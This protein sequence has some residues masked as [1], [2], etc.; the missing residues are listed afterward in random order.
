MNHVIL[1]AAALCAGASPVIV[2]A[3]SGDIYNLGTLGGN[4]SWGASINDAGQVAGRSETAE[5]RY[6]GFRYSGIPGSGGVMGDI[7]GLPP[8]GTYLPFS[9][10]SSINSSG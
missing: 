10:G 9:N 4:Y 6:H 2:R 8:D 3:A 7:G 1:I 5:D